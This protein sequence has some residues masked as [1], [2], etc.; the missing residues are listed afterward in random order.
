LRLGPPNN[1][2]FEIN[3]RSTVHGVVFDE[4]GNFGKTKESL[5]PSGK[6][7]VGIGQAWP[8]SDVRAEWELSSVW[9]SPDAS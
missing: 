9:I 3:D 1:F 6:T 8:L 7:P 4:I 5:A 2:S